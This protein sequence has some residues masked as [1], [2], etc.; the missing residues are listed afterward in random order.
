MLVRVES[1][2]NLPKSSRVRAARSQPERARPIRLADRSRVGFPPESLAAR[3]E[4]AGRAARRSP[5]RGG[6]SRWPRR[7]PPARRRGDRAAVGHHRRRRSAPGVRSCRP[8]YRLFAVSSLTCH[9]VIG[10]LVGRGRSGVCGSRVGTTVGRNGR[11]VQR[12]AALV[13]PALLV[14]FHLLALPGI[15]SARTMGWAGTITGTYTASGTGPNGPYEWTATMTGTSDGLHAILLP[16]KTASQNL[17]GSRNP[18]NVVWHYERRDGCQRYTEISRG[19]P[20]GQSK[21]L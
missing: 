5:W 8:S 1:H 10:R 17:Y 3:E 18:G 12:N 2:R 20:K 15:A 7:R 14:V 11:R 6:K 19:S 16:T 21:C 13:V 4:P 9:E